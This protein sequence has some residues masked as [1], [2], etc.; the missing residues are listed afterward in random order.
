VKP[1]DGR[2]LVGAVQRALEIDAENRES[3]SRKTE[4][5]TRFAR[6]TSREREVFGHL[7]TG[8]LNKQVAFDLNLAERTVKLHR[9]NIFA[10]LEMDSIPALVRLARDLEI[11]P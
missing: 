1:V 8:Q 7:I 10:K 5:R 3:R 2:V 11:Q 9:A 6:L 4:L